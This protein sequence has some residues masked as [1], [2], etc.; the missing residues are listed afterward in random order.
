MKQKMDH[1]PFEQMITKDVKKAEAKFGTVAFFKTK[2]T[3]T[4]E[5]FHKDF[6]EAQIEDIL[7]NYYEDKRLL[8]KYL[9]ALCEAYDQTKKTKSHFKHY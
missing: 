2:Y 4:A 7:T 6:F 5:N 8:K 9:I 1:P 3:E